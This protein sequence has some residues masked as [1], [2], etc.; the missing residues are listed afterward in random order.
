MLQ[1]L[2]ARALARR[3]VPTALAV[4]SGPIAAR[5]ISTQ[6]VLLFP[7]AKKTSCVSRPGLRATR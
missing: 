4:R 6:N 1:A 7:A 3:V 5:S 2:V